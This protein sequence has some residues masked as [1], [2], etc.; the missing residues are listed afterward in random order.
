MAQ[1]SDDDDDEIPFN[2]NEETEIDDMTDQQGG[3]FDAAK[4][5]YFT[6]KKASVRIR[7]EHADGPDDDAQNPRGATS[8]VLEVE[9]GPLGTD[10]KGTNAGRKLFPQFLLKRDIEVL[11]R[12]H[13]ASGKKKPFNEQWW[14]S[15]AAYATKVFFTAMGIPLKGAKANDAFL[16]ALQ[17]Q[18]FTADIKRRLNKGTGNDENELAG[19]KKVETVAD[20]AGDAED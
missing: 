1:Y 8:L 20:D 3:V 14:R 2:V 6:I 12:M 4:G 5:V 18:A 16:I 11:R 13:R 7:R 9:I 15:E 19:F 10:G 17:E